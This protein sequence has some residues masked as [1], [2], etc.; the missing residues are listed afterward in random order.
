MALAP[1]RE[2]LRS[3]ETPDAPPAVEVEEISRPVPVVRPFVDTDS[4]VPVVILSE[5]TNILALVV[6]DESI[7]TLPSL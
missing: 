6:A 3:L 5:E 4:P 7:I 1:E 2:R